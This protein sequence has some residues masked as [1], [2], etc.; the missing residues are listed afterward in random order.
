[1]KNAILTII[2]ITTSLLSAFADE[3]DTIIVQTIDYNTPVLPGW[4]S[5]RS[6]KYL[7]PADSISFSKVIMSYKL[8]CDPNQYPA[9]GE[10]DYTT[11]TKIIE[12]TGAFDSTLYYHP[13]YLVNNQSPDSFMMMLTP[14]ITYIPILEY[15]NF[16]APTN[17]SE[18]GDAS[19]ELTIPFNTSSPDGRLQSIYTST[20]LQ[21]AGLTSGDI[22]G[23]SFNIISGSVD[24]KHLTIRILQLSS[25]SLPTDT[26]INSGLQTVYSK[27]TTL[28]DG[29]STINFAFPFSWDGS[30]NLLIDISYQNYSGS[31]IIKAD[32]TDSTLA[33]SAT[34][35]D[36]ALDF[37]GWDIITI[38][39]QA[40]STI[41]SA[42]TISFWQ[43]GNPNIQPT[44]SSIFEAV[45]SLGRRVL[46][47]HLPWGNGKVYWDAGFDG[48][49]RIVG[50]ATTS[51]YLGQWN[52][53]TF[54]KDVKTGYMQILLNGNLWFIGSGK[55][56]LMNNIAEFRIGGA[57]TYDG[58]YAG[59]IDDFRVW[60]TAL[61]WDEIAEWMY[62]DI[63]ETHP[64]YNHLLVNYKFNNGTGYTVT[65]SSPNNYTGTQFGYPKWTGY[66]GVN[67]FKYLSESTL[68]PHIIIENG[69][70]N[71][72]SLDSLVVVDTVQQT[73][74][75]VIIFDPANP[76]QA[77]DTLTVWNS[78]YNNYVYDES[79]NAIDSTF[80]TPDQILYHEEYSYYGDPFEVLVPWEI[81]R[82][83][84]PYGNNLSLGDDGFTW[85]YTVTDYISL[86]RDSV[87]ITAGNFQELL[88][89]KF[90][91]IEGTPSRNLLK[92]EKVYSGYWELKNFTEKVPPD[93]IALLPEAQTF[94]LRTRTSGHLFSN[95]TNCAEFC[96][97]TH[98]VDVDGQTVKEWQIL[99]ECAENPL[100]PQGGTWIYDRA[101]WCPGMKVSEQ[102]IEITPYVTGDT[103][104]IDYN[105][106]YDQYGTY[107]LE[108]QLFSFGDLNFNVDAAIEEIIAPN[109]QKRY[110]RYNPSAS[111]PIIVISNQGSETLTS[112][113]IT[114]GPEGSQKTYLWTGNLEFGQKEQVTLEAFTWNDW[115]S[116]NGN[117]TAQLSNPNDGTD[118]NPI[119]N[120]YHSNYDLPDA[121]P[122]TIIIEFRTNKAAYQNSYQIF[123]TNGNL[124]FERNNFD[125]ETVY[126]DTVT[127][128]SGC[129][130]FY[131]W[132]TGDNGISFWANN[133]GAGYLKFS[134]V[135]GNLLQYFNG[136]FGDR[137]YKSFYA[138]IML[139]SN[140]LSDNNI[141]FDILPNPNNGDFVVSYAT[142]EKSQMDLVIYNSHGQVVEKRTN[143]YQSD[144]KLH[145]SNSRLPSGVYTCVLKSN[146]TQ[147]N[148]KFVIIN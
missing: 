42:I 138:D 120:T 124:V 137:I 125:N 39:P 106:Q 12:H 51:E 61:S 38:P 85:T 47:A 73:A 31:A 94:K 28:T 111:A 91:M 11:N 93:T 53:W 79:G 88:D 102:E 122:N 133:Q 69:N 119:N 16:T 4:N 76:T 105:S 107:S 109:N 1:M 60:D 6:G 113:T 116:G 100:Y 10:W 127:L 24:L 95:P 71:S 20:E 139:S 34:T 89:L 44:N 62:K 30:Q 128:I 65:D 75:N 8:K 126:I 21:S 83:I 5:P 136:D 96:D 27:N 114:Y 43:Y 41:D 134:D 143:I 84:T 58:Y 140:T 98:S 129:Y 97:K 115:Q 135:D 99:Q 103:V 46:N 59:M 2:I 110:S 74:V 25:S 64:M 132:D 23:L 90:L 63:D 49:D 141:T 45:D 35:P 147:V 108:V 54:I 78:Y 121:F 40:T 26:L 101:G 87:H 144:N 33:N 13:N 117:F 55:H 15:S 7:F 92:V 146:S 112:V 36:Y 81:G 57:L 22:T 3:G 32:L 56:K 131:M 68:R 14:S 19:Q 37:E 130:D 145:I 48:S 70:Y 18:P 104:V 67:R 17:L 9:C 77:T 86:L 72:A 82:F 148:K 118:E 80:V 66:D 50:Q 29:N 52:F 123:T 142:K